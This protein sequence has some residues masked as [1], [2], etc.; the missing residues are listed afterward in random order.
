[1]VAN[2]FKIIIHNTKDNDAFFLSFFNFSYKSQ[3]NAQEVRSIITTTK[4]GKRKRH[5]LQ[6]FETKGRKPIKSA[7]RPIQSL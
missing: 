2:L 3:S 5:R 1:M 4:I 6:T 7:T